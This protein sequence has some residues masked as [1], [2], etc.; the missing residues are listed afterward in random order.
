MRR[1]IAI[2]TSVLLTLAL[3]VGQAWAFKVMP[4]LNTY[5]KETVKS[6][7]LQVG[8]LKSDGVWIITQNSD[9]EDWEWRYILKNLQ[10]ASEHTGFL[11]Y[12]L[13]LIFIRV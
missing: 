6:A 3:F 4:S 12:A 7:L 10:T 1:A 11:L 5:K 8:K 2:T 13:F 9:F